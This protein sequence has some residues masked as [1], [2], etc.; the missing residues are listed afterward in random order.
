MAVHLETKSTAFAFCWE[1]KKCD[2]P[3]SIR[4]RRV[5]FCWRAM[6]E[7]DSRT[8]RYCDPCG[9]RRKWVDGEYTVEAFVEKYNRR[10]SPR[11]G[12]KVLVIDDDPH[13]LY[14]LEETVRHLG[15]ECVSACDAEDGLV[16]AKGIRPDLIITDIILPKFDGFDLCRRLRDNPGTRDTPVIIVTAR[17]RKKDAD[18]G[19]EVGARAFLVKPFSP[20]EL[21]RHIDRIL[22]SVSPEPR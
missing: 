5:L 13:I 21:S 4:E 22:T 1:E 9:Y 15:H 20:G 16:M 12:K 17:D 14:A 11:R 19:K 7:Y 10:S 6:I 2:K 3:C 18:H 8:P